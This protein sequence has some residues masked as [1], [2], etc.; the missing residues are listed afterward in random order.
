MSFA[1]FIPFTFFDF[2]IFK[3]LELLLCYSMTFVLVILM[4]IGYVHKTYEFG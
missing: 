4:S 1:H 2:T 3:Q